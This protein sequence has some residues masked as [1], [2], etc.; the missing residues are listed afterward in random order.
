MKVGDIVKLT[1]TF[2][3]EKVGLIVSTSEFSRGWHTVICGGE[4][5]HWPESQMEIVNKSRTNKL[6]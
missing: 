6:Y 2:S 4:Q 5:I 1:G 3:D